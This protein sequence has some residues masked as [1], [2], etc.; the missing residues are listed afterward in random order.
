MNKK[1]TGRGEGVVNVLKSDSVE[2]LGEDYLEF[3]IDTAL[4]SGVLKDIPFVSSV[5]GLFNVTG[6]IRDQMLATKII[7]FLSEISEISIDERTE[8][9]DKLNENDKFA[10]KL[11]ATLIEILDR[12]E[13]EVKPELSARC[14]VAYAKGEISFTELRHML[15]A[16]ERV[17]TFELAALEEFSKADINESL[18]ME[19]PTLLAF[20]NAGIGQN[21]GGLDGGAILPTKLCKLFVSSG[22]VKA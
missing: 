10:G 9:I 22:A 13:S 5:V 7:K 3:G 17:P 14:F 15:H 2:K 19:E 4:E 11:G 21:N 1:I 6:T 8:M 18:K 20:V 16:L 12:M